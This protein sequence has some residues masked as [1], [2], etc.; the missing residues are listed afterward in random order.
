MSQQFSRIRNRPKKIAIR[1]G[2]HHL[3]DFLSE[4]ESR[5][6]AAENG[7][8]EGN[9]ANKVTILSVWESLKDFLDQFVEASGIPLKGR[10][11]SIKIEGSEDGTNESAIIDVGKIKLTLDLNDLYGYYHLLQLLRKKQYTGKIFHFFL[12]GEER[13][14]TTK[15]SLGESN[16]PKTGKLDATLDGRLLGEKLFVNNAIEAVKN[17]FNV[18]KSGSYEL[19]SDHKQVFLIKAYIGQEKGIHDLFE[20]PPALEKIN[21]T[22]IKL[23]DGILIHHAE[24]IVPGI[25]FLNCSDNNEYFTLNEV[26]RSFI[27]NYGI[28]IGNYDA[29]TRC[30][31]CR[32]IILPKKK[33]HRSFCSPKCRSVNH[34]IEFGKDKFACFERQKQWFSYNLSLNGKDVYATIDTDNCKECER[35]CEYGRIPGGTCEIFVK[36]YGVENSKKVKWILEEEIKFAKKMA[37][38]EKTFAEEFQKLKAQKSKKD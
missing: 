26:I 11:L 1:K 31:I 4:V 5:I 16:K 10:E 30:F 24:Y 17:D 25:N 18:T 14:V 27:I 8:K 19:K 7:A 37:D 33:S 9:V 6:D 35:Y 38:E 22:K 12:L 13:T 29:I 32:K 34:M 3:I 28:A 20:L 15:I 36:K 21:E 2:M 23:E